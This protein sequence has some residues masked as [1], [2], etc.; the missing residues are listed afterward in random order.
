MILWVSLRSPQLCGYTVV[1]PGRGFPHESQT[2]RRSVADVLFAHLGR[3]VCRRES[4]P[5]SFLAVCFSRRAF[6]HCLRAHG[7]VPPA[8][9]SQN[10]ARRNLPWHAP[11]LLHVFRIL[12]SDCRP[13]VHYR[14]QLR[15][16]HGLQRRP[17]SAVARRI[18]G[19]HANKVD[20]CRRL[21]CA[22][23]P[24]CAT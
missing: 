22:R 19:A 3:H 21:R 13:P 2:A 1:D 5:R 11:G 14:H 20:L 24:V 9:H 4:R 17:G 6:H 15:L 8:R 12:L 10:P 7:A 23:R 16:C 18:L